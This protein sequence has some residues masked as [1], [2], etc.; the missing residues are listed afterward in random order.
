MISLRSCVN[1]PLLASPWLR[2][3][4]WSGPSPAA[5][6]SMSSASRCSPSRTTELTMRRREAGGRSKRPQGGIPLCRYEEM[7]WLSIL[8]FFW[9]DPRMCT[10]GVV[11][12]DLCWAAVGLM[13]GSF[14]L[15]CCW[16]ASPL[17]F[18][19]RWLSCAHFLLH[20]MLLTVSCIWKPTPRV[21]SAVPGLRLFGNKYLLFNKN[22]WKSAA[23]RSCAAGASPW[24][25]VQ[26]EIRWSGLAGHTPCF[27]LPPPLRCFP[28]FLS[29][30]LH[31][32][33]S[34]LC[35]DSLLLPLPWQ[36][37]GYFTRPF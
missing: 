22:V 6:T 32:S 28:F 24:L 36:Q 12:S 30:S 27:S 2:F 21:D 8:G 33:Y 10:A 18:Q 37:A 31:F 11:I 7:S 16:A 34:A 1:L 20:A 15:V 25:H 35:H 4:R 19:A 13:S 17:R 23:S 29:E 26:A 9:F 3:P 14:I 5:P